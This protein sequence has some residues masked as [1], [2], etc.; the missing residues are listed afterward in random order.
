MLGLHEQR[1]G[2]DAQ[3]EGAVGHVP[4]A[5]GSGRGRGVGD[6][7][8][9]GVGSGSRRAGVGS[10]SRRGMGSGSRRG[11]RQLWRSVAAGEGQPWSERAIG[12]CG[13]RV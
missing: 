7:S 8:G 6:G 5:V 11:V 12:R 2:G 1:R 9:R 4:G 10:G 3:E 13:R